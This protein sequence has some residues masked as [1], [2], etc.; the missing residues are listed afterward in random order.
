MSRAGPWNVRRA[1]ICADLDDPAVTRVIDAYTVHAS[2][3]CATAR[4]LHRRLALGSPARAIGAR[5]DGA[6]AML[7]CTQA[8][9]Q[10]SNVRKSAM[11]SLE[12]LARDTLSERDFGSLTTIQRGAT[13]TV[14]V[15]R[16]RFDKR[17]YVLKSMLK[18]AAR[19]EAYRF[20]PVI[21]SAVLS[22]GS[23]PSHTPQLLAAFQSPGSVHIVMEYFPA[24]DLDSLLSSAVQASDEYEGKSRGGGLLAEDWVVRYAVDIVAAVAW[25]HQLG[26]VHRDIKP[27]NFLLHRTGR[28]KLCDFA[29]CAPFSTFSHGGVP[30]R[31]VLAYYSQRPAGTCDYIAPEILR[32]E[33]R[34]IASDCPSPLELQSPGVQ[35]THAQPD[36][37]APG[38]YGP[39]VDW[40]SVGVVLYEMTFGQLPFWAPQ[41]AAVYTRI[42]HHERYFAM[43]PKV[44]CSEQLRLLI[45]AL[46]CTEGVRLGLHSSE[47]VKHHPVFG[48]VNW[49]ALD[50]LP[51]PFEPAL[52]TPS[53]LQGDSQL[54]VLHS[55]MPGSSS[56]SDVLTP[57]SFS[58]FGQLDA[59]PGYADSLD[60]SLATPP[61]INSWPS[62]PVPPTPGQLSISSSGSTD[63]W[64]SAW[65]SVDVHF[66]GFS[67]LPPDT[68]FALTSTAS[69]GPLASTP[70]TKPSRP[71]PVPHMSTPDPSVALAKRN[72]LAPRAHVTPLM[73]A[74]GTPAA[75]AQNSTPM[76]P[77]P[78]P[79]ATGT[80]SGPRPRLHS[81]RPAITPRM[82]S[83]Q[84]MHGAIGSDSRH[85]GGSTRKRDLTE[86]EAWAE[87]MDAVQR[88][89]RNMDAETSDKAFTRHASD[90]MLDARAAPENGGEM[91]PSAPTRPSPPHV[92]TAD[93]LSFS[94]PSSASSSDGS[95]ENVRMRQSIDVRWRPSDADERPALR[96]RRST[97]QLLL[98]AQ[99]TSTPTRSMRSVSFA[100]S[101]ERA[102]QYGSP[103]E[104]PGHPRIRR[105]R[106]IGTLR[107]SASVRDLREMRAVEPIALP[108]LLDTSPRAT[109][110]PAAVGTEKSS[111]VPAPSFM[112]SRR[113]LSEYRRGVPRL[114]RAAGDAEDPFGR[115]TS[116]ASRAPGARV[117]RRMQSSLGL[118]GSYRYGGA[119]ALPDEPVLTRLAREHTGLEG[120]VSSLEEELRSLRLRVQ[121][122]HP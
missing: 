79:V 24:G 5:L 45:A 96:P 66:Y 117:T 77:Y 71:S 89:A 107:A 9:G 46:V 109:N 27:S 41:P 113:M 8:R 69:P 14:E 49:D 116:L 25:V 73:P 52:E 29:T 35:G 11:S 30:Q 110:I 86:R 6:L 115:R 97:R 70:L 67:E 99:V 84:Q 112:D 60:S 103:Q 26:F 119:R 101:P 74:A 56:F 104:S 120:Q 95:P 40:W 50:K 121:N 100:A 37:E 98:D 80:F 61:A 16:C 87:M 48:H 21:E 58:T 91:P 43:D 82:V 33:E 75:Q 92:K 15:V 78:F 55:P 20:S 44:E 85:S 31:C 38:G 4:M 68:K 108:T 106:R 83:V 51:V 10:V 39:A 34:R 72:A 57:P 42:A 62:S 32:C 19:R 59:F 76:S 105:V 102:P 90:S 63:D 7:W 1:Q 94:S 22:S 88:S 28:L 3:E 18:G 36:T 23:E 2:C 65:A 53:A 122:G 64:R 17:L 114:T 54:S 111:P 13:G 12:A 81:P 93:E 47:Q 118:S